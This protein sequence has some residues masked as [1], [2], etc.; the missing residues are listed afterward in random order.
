MS[1]KLGRW[2]L[3]CSGLLFGFYCLN[4]AVGKIAL[5]SGEQPIFSIGDVGEF[6]VLFAAVICFMIT[7]LERESQSED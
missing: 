1:K 6:L 7:A 2:W 5:A 3:I 4:V